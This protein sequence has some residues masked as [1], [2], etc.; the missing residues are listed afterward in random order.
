MGVHTET[1]IGY[2]QYALKAM[3]GDLRQLPREVGEIDRIEPEKIMDM[4][5]Q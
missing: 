5:S 4:L 2:E 1:E 3:R